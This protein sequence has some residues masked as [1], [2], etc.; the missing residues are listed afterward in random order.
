MCE[1][2]NIKRITRNVIHNVSDIQKLYRDGK[3]FAYEWTLWNQNTPRC[4]KL[5]NTKYLC[6]APYSINV[7]GHEINK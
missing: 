7:Q 3:A 4:N 5:K 6:T 2:K 1:N